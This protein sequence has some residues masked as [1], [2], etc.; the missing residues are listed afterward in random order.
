MTWSWIYTVRAISL[1]CAA[2][3]VACGGEQASSGV[4]VSA[5]S[6]EQAR[7]G[8]LYTR[9]CKVCHGERGE[10]Y[11]ADN[12]SALAN[13]EFLASVSDEF[14]VAAIAHGRAGTP[15]SAWSVER[16]GPL[17][18][19]DIKAVIAF[20][21]A[22]YTGP[23]AALREDSLAGDARRGGPLYLSHCE[24]C[25]GVRGATG[26]NIRIGD[27][28]LLA[29]ATNGFLRHAIEKGRP[30]TPMVAFEGVLDR[31]AI[32][33]VIAYLRSLDNPRPPPSPMPPPATV[34]PIPLGPVPLNPHGPAP[35]GFNP[36]PNTTPADVV[37]AQLKVKARM[38]ILD[39]RAPSDYTS[40]HIAGAVSVPFY[41]PAPYFSQLP[42]NTWLVCYCA[43]PHAESR[44]LAAKLSAAGFKRVTVLDEGLGTWK[45]RG[46]G[47]SSGMQ[48]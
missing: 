16:G 44:E 27:R 37:A 23:R 36:H 6:T 3:L 2:S 34:P 29:A 45:Q 15:M 25:H 39:A 47:V 26:P 10:G 40:E 17:A 13:P 22:W 8:E 20:M 38:V 42:K 7:G 1:A 24:R 14:L 46:Y 9:M 41:D 18:A 12:A 11:K 48:P 19:Q 21:R 31:Q 43:C 4:E 5:L 35:R 32:D 33:D 30:G 28:A